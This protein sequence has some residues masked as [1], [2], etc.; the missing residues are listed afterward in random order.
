MIISQLTEKNTNLTLFTELIHDLS[1]IEYLFESNKIKY[2]DIELIRKI[3]S[4]YIKALLL[5]NDLKY[6]YDS[7]LIN[8]NKFYLNKKNEKSS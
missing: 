1:K 7:K 3:Q 4:K 5:K 6:L 8:Q 2:S